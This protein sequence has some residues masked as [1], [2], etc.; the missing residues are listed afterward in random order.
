[1]EKNLLAFVTWAFYTGSDLYI[2]FHY[3]NGVSVSEFLKFD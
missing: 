1:M 3:L 2:D